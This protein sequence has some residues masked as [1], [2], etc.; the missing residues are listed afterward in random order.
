MVKAVIF[1]LDGTLID[2]IQELSN[3]SNYA[4]TKMGCPTWEVSDYRTFV[5]NG[6]TRLL[7]RSLP[8]DR[9]GEINTARKY[10]NEYYTVHLLDNAPAYDGIPELIDKLR[11]MGVRIAVNTNKANEFAVRLI[12]HV[13]PGKFEKTVG[14]E[15]GYPRKPE[16]E[17]ALA[18]AEMMGA[19]PGE[20]IFMGDS[21]VD[22][23]TAKNAGMISV[24]CSWGFVY[25]NVLEEMDYENIIDSPLQLL[26]IIKNSI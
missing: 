5:G 12:D 22:L 15:G 10:F 20:C 16:P 17:A 7:L 4:L 19:K 26:D 2:T 13:F 1:D 11:E 25:R 18:L 6:I 23:A 14:D 8:E 21:G 3:A 9:R 24:L